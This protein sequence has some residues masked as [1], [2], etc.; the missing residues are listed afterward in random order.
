MYEMHFSHDDHFAGTAALGGHGN[1]NPESQDHSD[2]H[3]NQAQMNGMQAQQINGMNNPG[4][5]N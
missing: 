3:S 1:H 2:P 4:D 5:Q